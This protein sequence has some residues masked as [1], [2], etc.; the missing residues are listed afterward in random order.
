MLRL[1]SIREWLGKDAEPSKRRVIQFGKL[2]FLLILFIGLFWIIPIA[3]VWRFIRSADP[4]LLVFGITLGLLNVYLRSVQ[5]GLLTRIQGLPISIN[6]LFIVNLMVKFYLLFLPGT[7]IGSGIRWV[8]ISPTGKSA[9][10]LAAVAFNRFIETFLIII[11]GIFWFIVGL[12]QERLDF[13][14]IIYFFAIVVIAWIL[15]IKISIFLANWFDT[16]PNTIK[17]HS[18]WQF[19]LNYFR[20]TI[21]SLSIYAKTPIKDLFGIFG[22]GIL[23]YLVGFISYVSIARSTGIEISIFNLGWTRSVILLAAL[24]PLSIAGGLGIREVSL[25]VMLSLY[26]VEAEIALA[27]SLLLFSRNIFLSLIGGF[28]E[29]GETMLRRKVKST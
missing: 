13:R 11:T 3:D 24:T 12:G 18:N 7:I 2:I 9:E 26:G 19:I 29:L 21:Q 8:K 25:V 4:F 6:R 1:D 22:V 15:F 17:E 20:R 28:L 16:K 23:A 10:S 14:I 27:F 5:L